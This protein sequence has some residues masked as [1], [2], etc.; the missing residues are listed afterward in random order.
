MTL[1][2]SI[3]LVIRGIKMIRFDIDYSV[4]AHPLV[5]ERL[6]ENNEA[7]LPG[8]GQDHHTAAAKTLI[9][10]L[11]G[12]DVDVHFVMGGTQANLTIISSVLRPHQGVIAPETGHIA[13]DETGAIEATGHKVLELKGINGKIDAGQIQ[14]YVENHWNNPFHWH[15]SQPKMVYISQPTESGTLYSKEELE[16][17]RKVC[18]EKSLY[19][20]MDGARLTYAL[21]SGK[22]DMALNDYAAMCDIFYI[23][24]T[25]AGMLFG[26]AIVI[27]NEDMKEDFRYIIK[28][29]GGVLAKGGLLGIQFETLFEDDLYL[30]I[31]EHAVKMARRLNEAFESSG[32]EIRYPSPTNQIFPVLTKDQM[33]Q[34]ESKYAFQVWEGIDD[35]KKV[36]RFCTSWSTKEKDVEA[37]IEDIGKLH[38]IQ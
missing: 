1:N 32:I 10:R 14:E 2:S 21:A 18:D 31:A 11:C 3:E 16:A 4:G 9:R 27:P 28:Q 29:K 36:V 38:S 35:E 34:L 24:G 17:I 26:E 12:H 13:A 30:E 37:L 20:M 15:L 5:F 7:E 6:M 19:L 25:K 22:N 8:Y 33:E 23:G